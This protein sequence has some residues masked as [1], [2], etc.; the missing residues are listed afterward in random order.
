MAEFSE[1]DILDK[2][3]KLSNLRSMKGKTAEEMYEIAKTSLEKDNPDVLGLDD[4]FETRFATKK[5][6]RKA[7]KLLKKYLDDYSLDSIS[8]KNTI[9]ECVYLEVVQQRLQEKLTSFYKKD[10]QAIPTQM[11]KM[12]HDN[13]KAILDLK[14]SLGLNRSKHK[15]EK[16]FDAITS[17]KKRFEKWRGENQGS[18]TLLC[19]HCGKMT[20]LKIRMESWE[21]QKHPFFA[22]RVVANRHLVN[23][24]LED[25]ITRE[26]VAKVLEVSPDYVSW[27]LDKWGLMREQ[28][29]RKPKA[30]EQSKDDVLIE[31]APIE[32]T[33]EKV[34]IAIEI[35]APEIIVTDEKEVDK[36]VELDPEQSDD[37]LDAFKD[38][39]EE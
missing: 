30:I 39:E 35:K 37:I 17:L 22:D 21:A 12:V 32:D 29:K 2:A 5:E 23:M 34:E 1:D 28:D 18:R 27:L 3:K 26:D 10:E 36:I 6:V 15:Q 16:G 9:I 31:V 8:D 19:P 20:L 33:I 4:D 24:Y 11:M 38:Q 25:K 13:T 14:N 7:R